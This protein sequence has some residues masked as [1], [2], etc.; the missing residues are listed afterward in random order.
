MKRWGLAALV[1]LGVLAALPWLS[2][3]VARGRMQKT[4]EES[5]NRKVRFEGPSYWRFLPWPSFVA[6]QVTIEEDP[7]FSLEP[8]AYV[9]E[10]AVTPAWQSLLSGKLQTRRIRLTAPSVNLM[11]SGN[12][13]NVE[14]MAGAARSLPELEVRR[15]RV[16]FK[17]GDE[18][19]AFYLRNVLADFAAPNRLGEVSIFC[20]A[21]PARTDRGAQGFG[22]VSLRGSVRAFRE[23]EPTLDFQFELQPTAIHAFNFFFGARSVDFAG[24]LSSR[25]RIRGSWREAGIEGWTQFEGVESQS[26]LP[27]SGRSDR[28]D[29]TGTLDL[30]GQRLALDSK[31]NEYLRVRLRARDLFHSPRGA[32]LVQVQNVEFAKLLDLARQANAKLPEGFGAE[33]KFNGVMGYP[34]HPLRQETPARGMVWFDEAKINIPNA[35]PLSVAQA[36]LVVEGDAWSLRPTQL[37]AG[38]QQSASIEGTWTASRGGLRLGIATTE[39]G[40]NELRSGLGALLA[41]GGLPLLNAA[42]GGVWQGALSYQR[43]EE[44]DAGSWR[45]RLSLR[46]CLLGVE[47]LEEPLELSTAEVLFNPARVDVRRIR[48]VWDGVEVEGAYSYFPSSPKAAELDLTIGEVGWPALTKFFASGQETPRG[49]LERIRLRTNRRSGFMNAR[50]LEGRVYIRE[51]SLPQG[52][53]APLRG[54]L[55]WRGQNVELEVLN[56]A[57]HMEGQSGDAAILNGQWEINLARNPAAARFTGKVLRWPSNFGWIEWRGAVDFNLTAESPWDSARAEGTLDGMKQDDAETKLAYQ[58]GRWTLE[59]GGQKKPLAP[60]KWWPLQMEN[61]P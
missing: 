29:W 48:A 32:I 27:F 3:G 55:S 17:Q 24:N 34:I 49:L 39:L 50:A 45:G 23:Q 31:R 52:R 16:N 22:K 20:E 19:S 36:S 42:K 11:R 57:W 13:W 30:A 43:Q 44:T 18:K 53:I 21:E 47:G 51:L 15:G 40:L 38:R 7:R 6:E 61:E 8:F 5:L 25:G 28:L 12:G 10:I 41:R 54:L 60:A 35:P 9:E 58:Q 59:S 14:T 56:S 4:I 46:N 2:A 26:F 33:G 1:L 37:R